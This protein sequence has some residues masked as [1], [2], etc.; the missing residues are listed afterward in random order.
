MLASESSHTTDCE[1]DGV[2]RRFVTVLIITTG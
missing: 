1:P 2:E